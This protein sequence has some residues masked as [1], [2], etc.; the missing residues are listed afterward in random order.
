MDKR[1][2]HQIAC[3]CSACAVDGTLYIPTDKSSLMH[4][5]ENVKAEPREVVSQLLEMQEDNQALP[6]IDPMP[7]GPLVVLRFGMMQEEPLI[8][9]L[10]VKILIVDAM[11]LLHSMKKDN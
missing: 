2:G 4:A 6:Q 1:R 11:A 9:P 8:T 3:P 7:E 10:S 5:V